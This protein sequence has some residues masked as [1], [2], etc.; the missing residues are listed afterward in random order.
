MGREKGLRYRCLAV[1]HDDTAVRSTPGI[2]Y[3]AYCEALEGFYLLL[4]EGLIEHLSGELGFSAEE[5]GKEYR[6]WRS[7]VAARV[8]GFHPGFIEAL[9]E[10]RRRG[11]LVAVVSHSEEDIIRRDYAEGA[12]G[13]VP[14]AVFGWHDQAMRRKPSALPL[15][16]LMRRYDL[17]PASVLVLDDL[18]PGV[19]MARGAGVD[20]AAAGWAHHVPEIEAYMRRECTLY[21]ESVA[22]L[23]TLLTGPSAAGG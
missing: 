20:V 14:D 21:L 22:E 23:G 12:P 6:I 10:F 8:P 7:Y 2:H 17:S 11:G 16:E 18:R 3:P 1:D 13:F 4:Q 15:L 9:R 19:E 5:I